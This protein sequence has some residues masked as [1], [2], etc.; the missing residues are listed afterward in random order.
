[1]TPTPR[2]AL[3]LALVAVSLLVVPVPVAVLLA[4]A[5]VAA[6]A[7]DV[8]WVRRPP[9]VARHAPSL[10]ARGVRSPFR[11]VPA[12]PVRIRVRQPL[13]PDLELEPAQADG[14]LDGQL[15]AWRRGRHTLPPPVAR[16]TGPLGLSAW[17]HRVGDAADVLVY[18]DLPAARRLASAVRAGKFPDEGLRRRGP[19]GLGTEFES[20][21]DYSP[22]DDIRQ[23]NWRATARLGR[24]MSNQYRLERDRDVVC[25]VDCGRLMAAP[26]LAG[27]VGGGRDRT[28]LDAA[29]DAAVAVAAVA[30]VLGDRCGAIAF[31]GEVLRSLPPRRAGARD[32]VSALFDLEPVPVE[33]DYELAFAQIRGVKRAFVLVLTDLLEESAAQP[34]VEALPVLARRHAVGVAGSADPDLDAA[35]RSQP[36]VPGDVYRAAVA[37]EVLAARARAAARLQHAGATV[38]EAPPA[39]LAATCVRTYLRAKS[40]ARL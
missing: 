1:V 36:H 32:V 4:V 30:D 34:L 23:V 13:P 27:S 35:V 22:D 3:A 21:R 33:S 29:L 20:V 39:I 26:F 37:L 28:R 25:V 2:A 5:L 6:T 9:E 24:P 15:L 12:E 18:P 38:V 40:L 16:R 17:T 7:V 31:A 14:V 10:L 19:L 11:L 8:W